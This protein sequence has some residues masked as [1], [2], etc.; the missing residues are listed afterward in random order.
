MLPPRLLVMSR[1]QVQRYELDSNVPHA[2]I[3]IRAPFGE[4][5]RLKHQPGLL[6]VLRVVFDDVEEVSPHCAAIT[7]QQA[8]RIVKFAERVVR[9]GATVLICH[10]EAGVSRSAATAAALA[11]LF[12]SDHR[13]FMDLPYFPNRLVYEE[14]VNAVLRST[15]KPCVIRG[16]PPRPRPVTR[17]R[18]RLDSG[19]RRCESSC[20][21]PGFS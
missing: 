6:D 12:G 14:M 7:P 8:D 3:S 15:S 4:E 1:E 20:A 18:T 21:V 13:R 11:H 9:C 17:Q 10:C 2:I 16:I 5:S 19:S